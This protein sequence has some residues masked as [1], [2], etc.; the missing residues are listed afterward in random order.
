MQFPDQ[1][2]GRLVNTRPSLLG[3]CAAR[4]GISLYFIITRLRIA[5]ITRPVLQ[6]CR[7]GM[8]RLLTNTAQSLFPLVR[9]VG[10]LALRGHGLGRVA[11]GLND[12]ANG[13]HNRDFPGLVVESG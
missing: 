10:W 5:K 8:T 4:L 13:V 2:D 11:L 6:A 3:W 9:N 1:F 12:A 7:G